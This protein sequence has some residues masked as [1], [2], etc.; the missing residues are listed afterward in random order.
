MI[1]F[2]SVTKAYDTGAG[3]KHVLKNASC[4]FEPGH[5]FGVLGANGTGKSTLLRLI[6]GA[7]PPDSGRI[8]RGARV[9]FPLGFTGVFHPH[10][11]GRQNATFVARVYGADVRRVVEFVEEFAELAVYFDMPIRTYSAGMN[12]RLAFGVSLA[13]DFDIYL[14]DEVIE[15]GDAR[16]RQKCAHVLEQRMS[17][18]DLIMVS[19]NTDTIRMYCDAGAVLYGGEI[20]FFDSI[21]EALA[22]Y[23]DLTEP[24]NG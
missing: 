4:C 20:L 18:S 12:A 17:R 13:I 23:R 22:F 1:T 3:R 11:T 15:V 6:A 16:F 9:S 19:H 10:L 8:R 21:D 7:E 24:A 5:N 14:V 2:D